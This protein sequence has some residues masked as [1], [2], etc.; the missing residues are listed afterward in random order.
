MKAAQ[1]PTS[2]SVHKP[3]L[4]GDATFVRQLR[5][6]GLRPTRTRLAILS[7]LS[8]TTSHPSTESIVD[9]LNRRGQRSPVA[10]VYQNLSALTAHGLV[11]R[12]MDSRGT[13]RFDGNLDPHCH[14][15][16]T[17]CGKVA[18]AELDLDVGEPTPCS[19]E[20]D[21][22]ASWRIEPGSMHFLGVCPD[23]QG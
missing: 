14:L 23:C 18:D 17:G 1:A 10:T 21:G 2:D 7:L 3:N 13:A 6:R 16:C 5:R 4:G 15:V 11:L 20:D 19:A 9:E 8:E 22:A 12:F